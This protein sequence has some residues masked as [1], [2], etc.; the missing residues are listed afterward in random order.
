MPAERAAGPDVPK[1]QRH[2][3]STRDQPAA[4]GRRPLRGKRRRPHRELKLQRA[5][6]WAPELT[7]YGRRLSAKRRPSERAEAP[8]FARLVHGTHTHTHLVQGTGKAEVPSEAHGQM[9][10]PRAPYSTDYGLGTTRQ[11]CT[12]NRNANIEGAL[13]AQARWTQ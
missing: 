5:H 6:V 10:L 1:S 3:A 11:P 9:A 13:A 2:V 7:T 4:D 12:N 8:H